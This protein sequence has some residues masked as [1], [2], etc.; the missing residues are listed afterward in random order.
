MQVE[1]NEGLVFQGGGGLV[2]HLKKSY[3]LSDLTGEKEDENRNTPHMHDETDMEGYWPITA[4][5]IFANSATNN[6]NYSSKFTGELRKTNKIARASRV[7]QF[8]FEL[9]CPIRNFFHFFKCVDTFLVYCTFTDLWYEL[10]EEKQKRYEE[11]DETSVSFGFEMID[12]T[13]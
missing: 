10:N 1:N 7:C 11:D 6:V 12:R 3:S 2:Q 9:K 4:L 5:I 13:F 8:L